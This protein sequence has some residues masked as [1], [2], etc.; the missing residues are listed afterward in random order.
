MGDKLQ[1]QERLCNK[2]CMTMAVHYERS[3]Y[4]IGRAYC[5]IKINIRQEVNLSINGFW[6]NSLCALTAGCVR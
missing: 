1:C 3:Q 2:Q 5:N 6:N 4:Q